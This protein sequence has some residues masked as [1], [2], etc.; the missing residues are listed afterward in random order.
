MCR[1]PLV[2]P[3]TTSSYDP[4]YEAGYTS[5]RLAV[6]NPAV[7][8][9]ITQAGWNQELKALH[10][11]EMAN[12][13]SGQLQAVLKG[14]GRDPGVL[15]RDGPSDALTA[16]LDSGPG[17]ACT[18]VRRQDQKRTDELFQ[19]IQAWL[20]PASLESPSPQLGRCHECDRLS[21][22]GEERSELPCARVVLEEERHN[23]SVNE[24]NVRQDLRSPLGG[25][26]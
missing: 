9:Q 13:V 12:I 7:N 3:S 22:A 15:H 26:R 11:L 1:A 21:L 6:F 24:D 18:S 4:E 2:C 17:T 5:V 25:W 10:S 16:D 19:A 14:D 8:L 23:V 20:A